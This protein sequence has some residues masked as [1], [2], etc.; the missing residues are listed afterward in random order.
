MDNSSELNYLELQFELQTRQEAWLYEVCLATKVTFAVLF[1]VLL[2]GGTFML[3]G[4]YSYEK[5][6]GDPQKRNLSNILLSQLCLTFLIGNWASI[7]FLAWRSYVG[8]L[9]HFGSIFGMLSG[10]ICITNA[11]LCF[12]PTVIVKCHQ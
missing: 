11:I 4:I 2:I 7:P 10:R 6:G 12:N 3:F 1:L 9:G 8:T 5:Y